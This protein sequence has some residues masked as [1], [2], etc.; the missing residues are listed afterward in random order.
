MSRRLLKWILKWGIILVV[1]LVLVLLVVNHLTPPEQRNNNEIY[2]SVVR[3]IKELLRVTT[4]EGDR[5][6]PVTLEENGVGAF[7]I[8]SY[9]VRISYDVEQLETYQM[10]DTLLVRLPQEEIKILENDQ[11]GFR[12]IDVWGTTLWKRLSGPQLS[13]E[14][15][16]RMRTMAADQLR[17]ELARDGSVQK[18]RT[19]AIHAVSDMLS[20]VPGT[21]L[22]L[23]PVEGKK[24]GLL[25][26]S[27]KPGGEIFENV[28]RPKDGL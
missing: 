18:A 21:V 3:D 27:I 10:G 22:V 2:P 15:E 16:N 12:V 8:G 6:V 23:E 17:K 24:Q 5:T 26:P 7:A 11:V 19:Q 14:Q 13:L 9:K 20:L 28:V 4:L 25:P 1:V